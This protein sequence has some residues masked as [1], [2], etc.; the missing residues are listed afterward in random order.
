MFKS[1]GKLVGYFTYDVKKKALTELKIVSQD[2]K[3]QHKGAFRPNKKPY[4]H[5]IGI[6][7][8]PPSVE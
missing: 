7:L 2:V 5:E 6:E 1:A 3:Y 8:L 4:T